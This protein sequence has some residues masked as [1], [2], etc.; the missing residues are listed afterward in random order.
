[1]SAPGSDPSE[2]RPA[3]PERSGLGLTPIRWTEATLG[4]RPAQPELTGHRLG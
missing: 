4:R 3:Q 2:G 1:M